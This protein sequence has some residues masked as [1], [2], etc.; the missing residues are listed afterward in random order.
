[1]IS[2]MLQCA[3]CGSEHVETPPERDGYNGDGVL[4][5]GYWPIDYT[6]YK[7]LYEGEYVVICKRVHDSL[8]APKLP[9]IKEKGLGL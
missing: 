7:D 3:V 4:V 2:T 8:L 5:M 9:P 1:M 6:Y